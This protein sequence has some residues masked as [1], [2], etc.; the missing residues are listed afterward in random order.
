VG[1]IVTCSSKSF[2]CESHSADAR[3]SASR[4][5]PL[6]LL[7]ANSE[8]C[9][10]WNSADVITC[11]VQGTIRELLGTFRENSGNIQ[12]TLLT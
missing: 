4:M 8:Q 3:M 2:E 6:L 11:N 7:Y 12:G 9:E 5:L 1:G 10:G